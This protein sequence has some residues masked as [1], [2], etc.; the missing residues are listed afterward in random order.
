M[1]DVGALSESVLARSDFPHLLGLVV[2]RRSGSRVPVIEG[3]PASV[4]EDDLKAIGAAAASS[5]AV[6]MFHAVGITPEAPTRDAALGGAL[7]EATVE[8]SIDALA[9]ARDELT[10]SVAGPLAAVSVGTPHASVAELAAL[11]RLLDGRSVS[12]HLDMYV[13]RP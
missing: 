7:P 1:F 6:G 4:S 9:A 12:S 10:T 13:S 11:V 8:V 2:G 5:G 3:L